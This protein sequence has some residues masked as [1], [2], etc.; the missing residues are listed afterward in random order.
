MIFVFYSVLTNTDGNDYVK[1]TP[2][3]MSLRL[4]CAYLFHLGN[5]GD[6]SSSFKRLKHLRKYPGDFGDLLVPAF[7]I[8]FYQFSASFCCE[9]MNLICLVR[10]D[11]LVDIIMNYV[12][13]AGISEIDNLYYISEQNIKIKKV[14]AD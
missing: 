10:Q 4:L 8:T 2:L 11:T 13:F 7:I 3:N 5:Y 14:L 1:P 9:V 12:A 6:V